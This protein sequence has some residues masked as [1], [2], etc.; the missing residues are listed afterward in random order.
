MERRP[1]VLIEAVDDQE[2]LL[3]E[4]DTTIHTETMRI[5]RSLFTAE[6]LALSSERLVEL[7]DMVSDASRI[8]V[9]EKT[10][11]NPSP[12]ICLGRAARNDVVIADPTVSSSQA[13]IRFDGTHYHLRDL[14]SANGTYVNRLKVG[15]D[16]QKTLRDG[17]TLRLGGRVFYFLWPDTFVLFVELRA[18][19]IDLASQ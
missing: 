16:E 11:D 4:R 14:E 12:N 15:S 7:Q 5:D 6:A 19:R 9:L 1:A 18:N 10:G 17:D 8:F 2:K 3:R 13:S